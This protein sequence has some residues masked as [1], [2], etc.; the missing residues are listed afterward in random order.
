MLATV[1]DVVQAI[2][3]GVIILLTIGLVWA[4]FQYADAAKKTVEEMRRQSELQ[5]RLQVGSPLVRALL[6]AEIT[7]ARGGMGRDPAL[8]AFREYQPIWLDI[9]E[10]LG[11]ELEGRGTTFSL[12]FGE[13]SQDPSHEK[14]D[15]GNF[16]LDS[17][18]RHRVVR[19]LV[20]YRQMVKRWRRM[21]EI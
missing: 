2:S 17:R 1:S 12:M 18:K 3:S 19:A 11:E 20:S 10:D 15:E 16:L 14:D 4:T 21:E 9:G 6:Q 13:L 5:Y 7:L 8:E